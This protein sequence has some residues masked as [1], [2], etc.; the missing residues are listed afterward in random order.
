MCGQCTEHIFV[1]TVHTVHPFLHPL[2]LSKQY[3]LSFPII[4]Y[5]LQRIVDKWQ[6][7][8]KD[9][10]TQIFLHII[11]CSILELLFENWNKW[12]N[13]LHRWH[14][15][16]LP[17]ESA[18]VVCAPSCIFCCLKS[19]LVTSSAMDYLV[20]ILPALH[21]VPSCLSCLQNCWHPLHFIMLFLV[22]SLSCW[23]LRQ[24]WTILFSLA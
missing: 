9:L 14:K 18:A 15:N 23:R 8:R 6:W 3:H 19:S 13:M 24:R 22:F 7:K 17:C 16:S 12:S 5:K 4:S 1:S 11:W 2:Q 10:L 21:H 20:P